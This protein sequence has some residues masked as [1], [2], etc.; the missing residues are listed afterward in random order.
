MCTV[1]WRCGQHGG[2]VGNGR[3]HSGAGGGEGGGGSFFNSGLSSLPGRVGV[4]ITLINYDSAAIIGGIALYL[5]NEY[6]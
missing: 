2:R 3:E 6:L 4:L 1:R 5:L